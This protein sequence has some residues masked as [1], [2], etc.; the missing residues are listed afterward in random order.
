[1]TASL[2][3]T[4]TSVTAIAERE[5][6]LVRV[7]EL[8]KWFGSNHCLK[9]IDLEIA[10]GEVIAVIGPSGSGKSTLL[11]CINFLEEPSSGR[12]RV[13]DA[14]VVCGSYGRQYRQR[15]HDV[16]LQCGMVFQ[17]FNLFPHRSV[18][19]NVADTPWLLKRMTKDAARQQAREL[20]CTVGLSD[21]VEYYP[22]Q[23]SG[24]QKQRVAI[25]RALAMDPK[26]MLFDEPTS[27]LDPELIGE[28]LRV[29]DDLAESGMTMIV[30]SHEMHFARDAADRVLFMDD[31][32]ILEEGPPSELFA[33]PREER[34]RQF[35][36]H[37]LPDAQES[38]RP[39]LP[40]RARESEI[41]DCPGGTQS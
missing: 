27:A 4:S 11:R 5:Q 33:R 37:I 41:S 15:M 2:H 9:G 8:H 36:R 18:L 3:S 26:L 13:D 29:M 10:Q 28:V 16:R 38:E 34:T 22:S 39:V 23:L 6:P 31:G 40:P 30:V 12:I 24:G 19:E 7:Q 25:A 17:E 21:R 20:L 14:T 35:L 32:I 1:M